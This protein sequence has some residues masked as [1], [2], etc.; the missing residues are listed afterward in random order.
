MKMPGEKIRLFSSFLQQMNSV[1]PTRVVCF[2]WGFPSKLG[3]AEMI[4]KW[5]LQ[6]RLNEKGNQSNIRLDKQRNQSN[7][8]VLKNLIALFCY[9][10]VSKFM[11][12]LS[13]NIYI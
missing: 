7:V 5:S 11:R 2:A 12:C 6:F 4:T 3:R 10:L 9:P 8:A 13:K 1:R